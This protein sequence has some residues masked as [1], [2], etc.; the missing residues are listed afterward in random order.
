MVPQ[1][2]QNNEIIWKYLENKV[3]TYVVKKN[4]VYVITGPVYTVRPYHTIGKGVAV[5]DRLFKI[6][7]DSVTGKSISFM[8]ANVNYPVGALNG[9][10]VPLLEIENVTGITFN[11]SLDKN[12]SASYQEWFSALK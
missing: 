10:I 6:V 1:N 8:M 9:K 7:I 12:K 4:P 5:P 2:Y 11:S 3:R